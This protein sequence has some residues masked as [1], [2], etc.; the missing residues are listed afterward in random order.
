MTY[1]EY[2]QVIGSCI[3][4][5]DGVKALAINDLF[6]VSLSTFNYLR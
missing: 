3:R 4:R 1:S 2:P 5:N 6:R